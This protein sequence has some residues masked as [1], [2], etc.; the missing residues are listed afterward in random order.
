MQGQV[1]LP[2]KD[3]YVEYRWE[4]SSR[5]KSSKNAGVSED[6]SDQIDSSIKNDLARTL[7]FQNQGGFD[8][9]KSKVIETKVADLSVKVNAHIEK[10]FISADDCYVLFRSKKQA[11]AAF[12]EIRN[13]K[14]QEIENVGRLILPNIFQ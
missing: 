11:Q 10:F 2:G 12:K 6:P 13:A 1:K 4:P 7:F 8:A 9:S 5:H 14:D 3:W